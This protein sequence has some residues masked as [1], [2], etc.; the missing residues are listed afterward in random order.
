MEQLEGSVAA[1]K[2]RNDENGYTVFLV[3]SAGEDTVVVGYVEGIEVGEEVRC[4]GE[5]VSH[6]TYGPQLAA[7]RIEVS[8]P[9]DVAGIC[10]YLSGGAI[11]GVGEITAR[12]IVDAFGTDTL[13]V[14]EN[15]YEQLTAVKG[16]T[17]AKAHAIHQSYCETTGLKKVIAELQRYK[18]PPYVSVRLYKKY[19]LGSAAALASNPY[20]LCELDIGL[21]FEEADEIAASAGIGEAEHCRLVAGIKYV[22]FHNLQNGHTFLPSDALLGAAG[23]LLA[24]ERFALEDVLYEMKEDHDVE[25]CEIAGLEAVYLK[26]YF[27]AEMDI[28]RRLKI[29]DQKRPAEIRGTDKLIADLEKRLGISYAGLQRK[30]IEVCSR[31]G[32]FVLTGGPGTGKTTTLNGIISLFLSCD[33]KVQLCAPTGRAAKRMTEVTGMEAKTVHRL[34][35]TEYRGGALPGFRRNE[36]NPLDVDVV[37]VDEASMLDVMLCDAL[38][39]AVPAGA[40]MIFIGDADQLPPVGAGYVLR[41]IIDSEMFSCVELTE[42]FR[43]AQNSLIVVNAHQINAGEY[44]D[45]EVKDNDFFF[46]KRESREEIARTVADLCARRLPTRMGLDPFN[47]IQVIAPSRKG[48]TGTVALNALLQSALNPDGRGRKQLSYKGVVFREGD[49]IMQVRNNY[50]MTY[51]NRETGEVG[52]GVYNGDIGR[53][54]E[55]RPGEGLLTVLFD[56][57]LCEY[58]TENLGDLEHAYAVTVHKSQGSEFGAVILPCWFG[59]GRLQTRNLLYT[60]VTRA[61][62]HFIAVGSPDAMFKMVDN[63]KESKRFSGLRYLICDYT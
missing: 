30:A 25:I 3:E 45:V 23:R 11:R 63:N 32:V 44:P 48:E 62:K 52:A 55:I 37:I 49:K 42:I 5:Y 58:S 1:V 39:R 46:L 59:A 18:L 10:A 27:E 38:L 22:L 28:A 57:R 43:Q 12:R 47:D 8:L 16:I 35:E 4:E 9:G 26:E 60:A 13:S 31:T 14:I 40:R 15:D 51:L 33:C 34:L 19:G 61:K 29:L 6:P 50:D 53:I 36:K 54:E 41:D 7:E 24:A 17:R 2:Y 21:S 20:L 56:D